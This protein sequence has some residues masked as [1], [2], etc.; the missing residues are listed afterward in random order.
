MNKKWFKT[1]AVAGSGLEHLADETIE[2]ADITNTF[3]QSIDIL[4]VKNKKEFF[5]SFKANI[6]TL[7]IDE[8]IPKEEQE[9]FLLSS[10]GNTF[11]SMAGHD[12][13]NIFAPLE[14]F[15]FLEEE[16]MRERISF[17]VKF[18]KQLNIAGHLLQNTR[19]W[20]LNRYDFD[21]FLLTVKEVSQKLGV[22]IEI[23]NHRN[24]RIDTI[25]DTD[26][27]NP[28][29]DEVIRNWKLHGQDEFVLEVVS[30]KKLVFKNKINYQFNFKRAKANLRCPFV[31]RNNSTGSG[32]GLF[33]VSLSSVRGGFDWDISVKENHF[34]LSFLF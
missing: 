12:M 26:I 32:L 1:A 33:I 25:P 8:A 4:F 11:I 21:E 34:S 10:P 17:G 7:V 15:E 30:E 3:L 23:Q 31:K 18:G 27:M 29:I 5:S 20:S 28:V 16:A 22:K 2:K 14:H 19:K 13:V 9:K 6:Y 24:Y